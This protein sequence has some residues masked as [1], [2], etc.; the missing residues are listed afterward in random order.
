MMWVAFMGMHVPLLTLVV[1]FAIFNSYPWEMVLRVVLVTLLATLVGTAATLYTLQQLLAPVMASSDALHHYLYDRTLPNL[2]TGFSDE[3]GVLMAD[4]SKTLYQLDQALDQVTN[5]NSLTGLPNQQLFCDRLQKQLLHEHPFAVLL[6]NLDDFIGVSNALGH[7][8]SNVLLSAVAQRLFVDLGQS[9]ATLAHL[10]GDE[11]AIALDNHSFEDIIIQSQ[12][13]IHTFKKPFI[14]NEQTLH[15]GVSIGITM[16]NDINDKKDQCIE[17]LLHNAR[18]ALHQ[19]KLQGRN[20]YQF[21]SSHINAEL[22][23]RL[24]LENDLYHALERQEIQVYYQPLINLKTGSIAGLEAL[25]RWEHPVHGLLSPAHFIHIAEANG[26]IIPIGEWIL[27]TACTQLRAWQLAGH[28]SIRISVNLAAQQFEYPNLSHSINQILKDTGL[29]PSCLE[30]EVTESSLMQDIPRSI[31]TLTQLKETGILIALDDFG[32]G[33]SSLNYLKL[34][35]INMLKIDRSFIHDVTTN[36]NSAAVTDAIIALAKNLQLTIT[37][38]GVETQAQVDYLQQRGCHE[39]QGFYFGHPV[40]VEQMTQ[41]LCQTQR[42]A[43][44]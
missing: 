34:F 31:A 4:V 38:E 11:F 37:A 18:I 30:L 25:V 15:M 42:W 41:M 1:S 32:T 20:Q 16:N 12:R 24:S 10:G 26:L 2:P 6:L 27:R 43:K 40:A 9:G 19:A 44:K 3:V 17:Q 36:S 28:N 8:N 7:E 33:Y 13:I 35:P 5:Y 29:K 22:Q 21:Y 23:N 39:G 14:L